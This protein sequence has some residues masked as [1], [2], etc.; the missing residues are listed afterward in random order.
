MFS[1][2]F[3][4]LLTKT[5]L[6][7]PMFGESGFLEWPGYGQISYD[8]IKLKFYWKF[9]ASY[10]SSGNANTME[11]EGIVPWRKK[12][13]FMRIQQR[14]ELPSLHCPARSVPQEFWLKGYDT[15]LGIHIVFLLCIFWTFQKY[16]T[17]VFGSKLCIFLLKRSHEH[18]R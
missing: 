1:F 3:R 16:L 5:N 2:A 14:P 10:K 18:S 12:G 6:M 13:E 11:F 9:I 7:C 15:A 8:F 17:S 4:G